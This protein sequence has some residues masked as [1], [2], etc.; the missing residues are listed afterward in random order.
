MV[1]GPSCLFQLLFALCK[2]NPL[3]NKEPASMGGGVGKDSQMMEDW[4]QESYLL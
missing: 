1:V 2:S 4:K 3:E